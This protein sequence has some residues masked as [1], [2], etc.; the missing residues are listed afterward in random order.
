MITTVGA[1]LLAFFQNDGKRLL[2]ASTAS[3][4][5]YVAVCFSLGM[6]V[7]ALLL[8]SF[9]CCGKAITFVWFGAFMRRYRGYS[10]FRVIGGV[11]KFA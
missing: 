5:G 8:L 4:L 1:A 9:C 11:F 6:R 2:A 3:Q 10:D 7:E